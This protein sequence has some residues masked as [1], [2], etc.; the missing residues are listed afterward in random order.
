MFAGQQ[1]AAFPAILT[2]VASFLTLIAKGGDPADILTDPATTDLTNLA[3]SF[4]VSGLIA[5]LSYDVAFY[6]ANIAA[7]GTPMKF[8]RSNGVV[9]N[10][11]GEPT[12][13]VLRSPL[14]IGALVLGL[15]ALA[16]CANRYV[17]ET[18]Q[19][20]IAGAYSDLS[21]DPATKGLSWQEKTL[22]VSTACG[23]TLET[24]L[25]GSGAGSPT[26]VVA[27]PSGA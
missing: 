10:K 7:D 18:Q 19:V 13:V 20:C 25:G 12:G 2:F 3:S 23:V 8:V 17:S 21:A 14:W 26:V 15:L 27:G 4:V 5:G 6:K 11:D 22:R 9:V 24:L 1:K 16:A